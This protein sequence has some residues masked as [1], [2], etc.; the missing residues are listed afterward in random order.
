M[1]KDIGF[2]YVLKYS[3]PILICIYLY[4]KVNASELE[5]RA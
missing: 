1:C 4:I 2:E 3:N 5:V